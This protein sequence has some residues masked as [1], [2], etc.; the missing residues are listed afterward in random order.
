M[1]TLQACMY[2]H[3]ASMYVCTPCKHVCMY[4]HP[5]SMYVCMHTLQACMYVCTPCKHVCMYA[6]PASMYV[7]TPCK[8]VCMYT[9]QACM[10]VCTPCKH[11]CMY[12]HPASMYACTLNLTI[13]S[14]I[15]ESD[16]DCEFRFHWFCCCNNCILQNA[17]A[18]FHVVK[19]TTAK[20]N[21]VV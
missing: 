3:P 4:A 16:L 11:V 15:C 5:A 21:A 19:H 14:S 18:S 17:R 6:H 10:Y 20:T 7:C 1:H 13:G 2:A 12:A 9:L 8:H